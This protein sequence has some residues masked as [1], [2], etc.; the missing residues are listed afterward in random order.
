[1]NSINSIDDLET[2][3]KDLLDPLDIIIVKNNLIR[4]WNLRVKS[5]WT[6]LGFDDNGW[7]FENI[8][9][10]HWFIFARLCNTIKSFVRSRPIVSRFE[11][12][13]CENPYLGCKSLEELMIKKDLI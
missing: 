3:A 11:D 12:V 4:G 13:F 8:F 7:L 2:L 9:D 6:Q 10:L 1:M 5:D